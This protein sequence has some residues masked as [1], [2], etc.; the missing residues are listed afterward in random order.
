VL[1]VHR[2]RYNDWGLPKGKLSSNELA[3]TAAVREFR[4]ETGLKIRRLGAP[5]GVEHYHVGDHPKVVHW[6][7]G[8]ADDV[9]APRP[10]DPTEIDQAVWLPSDQALERLNYA[11]ER[12]VLHRA[13]AAPPSVT[14]LV[15]RHAK[16]ID[17]AEWTGPDPLRTLSLKGHRQAAALRRVLSA[18]GVDTLLSS[19]SIRCRDTFIPYATMRGLTIET[20]PELSEEGAAADPAAVTRV[21]HELRE[22]TLADA[23]STLAICGH[24]PV[25]PDMAAALNLPYTPMKPSDTLVAHLGLDSSVIAVERHHLKS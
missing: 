7:L 20:F 11:D 8:V 25:L 1:V 6:W 19:T 13:L 4:E 3:V 24:R 10:F 15:I 17:R 18:Y 23:S 2:P 5:L 21:M 22:R 9:S 12:A 14:L 16:A